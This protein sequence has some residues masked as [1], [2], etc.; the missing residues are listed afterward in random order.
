MMRY[1][2]H[3]RLAKRFTVLLCAP[4]LF[5]R[6]KGSDAYKIIPLA[7]SA[8]L[9]ERPSILGKGTSSKLQFIVKM[10]LTRQ[11]RTCCLFYFDL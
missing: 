6:V 1:V 7:M 11:E 8:L 10:Q 9:L 4:T 2:L 3:M 5:G